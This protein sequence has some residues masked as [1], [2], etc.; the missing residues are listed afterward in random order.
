[1]FNRLSDDLKKRFGAKVWKLSVDAGLGCPN[2]DGTCGTGGCIFCAGSSRFIPS[3]S[4]LKDSLEKAKKVLGAKADGALFAAYFQN[5]TNTYAPVQKLRELFLPIALRPDICALFIGTRPDCLEEDKLELLSEIARIKP[6]WV[7]LGLQTSND[8]T[9]A[10]LNRGYPTEVFDR[11]MENLRSAGINRTVHCIASLPGETTDD[12][13][14]TADH[15]SG[16]RPEGVKLHM[17][18]VLKNTPL[19]TLWRNGEIRL[20]SQ[21]EYI[22]AAVRF[23]EAMHPD[24]VIHR[25]TGDGDKRVLIAPEWTSD[26]RHVLNAL[27]KALSRTDQGRFYAHKKD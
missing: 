22:S 11:A 24:T 8:V 15:I 4:D 26:K 19:E 6:V 25:L 9:A 1:M 7:E 12:L 3:G 17:L 20:L 16:F 27:E 18:H 2:R 5:G 14:A 10:R 13:I 21:E 23:V